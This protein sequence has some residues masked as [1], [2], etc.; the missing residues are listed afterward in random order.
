[1]SSH[2]LHHTY[3]ATV[4]I[5]S[6]LAQLQKLIE[7]LEPS[8][9]R[10]VLSQHL[11]ALFALH[12][13][14]QISVARTVVALTKADNGLEGLLELLHHARGKPVQPHLLA[15]LIAPL[16]QQIQYAN[17]ES[18]HLL[19]TLLDEKSAPPARQPKSLD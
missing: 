8:E 1:M 19:Y 18:S 6:E 2:P 4:A 7:S 17:S 14:V 15:S 9:E 3:L 13:N 11:G 5:S 10:T 16:H 12:E